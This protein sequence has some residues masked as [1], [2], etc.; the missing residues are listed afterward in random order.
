L[1]RE[2]LERDLAHVMGEH[3]DNTNGA[4]K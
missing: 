2:R 1:E 3:D 4:A